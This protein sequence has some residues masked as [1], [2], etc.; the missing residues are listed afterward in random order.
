MKLHIFVVILMG[1]LLATVNANAQ[2]PTPADRGKQVRFLI[3][4]F[5]FAFYAVLLTIS[6]LI[7]GPTLSCFKFIFNSVPCTL[8][9]FFQDLCLGDQMGAVVQI[10]ELIYLEEAIDLGN[11]TQVQM[12]T[13]KAHAA[14][15]LAGVE[16]LMHIANVIHAKT[17]EVNA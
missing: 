12:L 14:P 4:N 6:I 13:G 2:Y 16:I 5:T 1:A 10:T 17:S 7:P 9:I 15:P 11:V 8:N 3:S